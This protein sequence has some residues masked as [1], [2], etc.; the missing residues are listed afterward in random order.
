MIEIATCKHPSS[1]SWYAAET[2]EPARPIKLRRYHFVPRYTLERARM[3][4]MTNLVWESRRRR[5]RA[6]VSRLEVTQSASP[7]LLDLE[8]MLEEQDEPDFR[9]RPSEYAS[10]VVREII[11]NSYTHYLGSAPIPAIA[12]DGNGGLVVEWKSARRIVRLIIS[13]NEGGK[14]YV[15]SRGGN[16]SQ[17]E[18]SASGLIVAHQLRSIF[19]D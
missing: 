18:H 9:H 5:Q 7:V 15:Y 17:V 8:A 4:W 16:R 19:A 14:N 12:P 2:P 6:I 1:F 11:E 3:E 13:A 10:S